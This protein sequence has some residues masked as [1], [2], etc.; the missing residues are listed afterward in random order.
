M[1]AIRVV[2]A[3]DQ[4]LIVS[5]LQLILE[6]DPGISVVGTAGTGRQAIDTATAMP[7]VR[8]MM[9]K[10]DGCSSAAKLARVMIDATRG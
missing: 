10:L 6:T 8:R 1:P 4:P 7:R 5:S 9:S 3:D 2:I